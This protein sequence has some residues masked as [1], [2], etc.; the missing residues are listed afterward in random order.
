M[1]LLASSSAGIFKKNVH[2]VLDWHAKIRYE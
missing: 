2:D 1:N